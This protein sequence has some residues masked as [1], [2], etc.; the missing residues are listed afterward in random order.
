MKAIFICGGRLAGKLAQVEPTGVKCLLK[1]KGASLLEIAAR[2]VSDM[3]PQITEAVAVGGADVGAEV[4][5]IASRLGEVGLS[6]SH[7]EEGVTVVDNV[8]IGLDRLGSPSLFLVVSPDL[9]VLTGAA[10]SDFTARRPSDADITLPVVTREAFLAR[11]PG[12]PTRFEKFREG[13]LTLGSAA[14]FT[15]SAFT[16][17]VP[18]FTDAFNVRKSPTRMLGMLGASF[19]L[20]ALTHSLSIP[21]VEEKA[22]RITDC[23]VKGTLDCAAELAFDIDNSEELAFIEKLEGA[24]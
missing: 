20:A 16:K 13:Y 22:S 8:L 23:V 6:L 5:R 17:N 10:L 21:M 19:I 24:V 9:P 4:E 18:L 14:V 11:F 15:A 2:A 12:S 7:A 3:K 1:F